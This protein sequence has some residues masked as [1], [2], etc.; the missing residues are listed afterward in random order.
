MIIVWGR[1][2]I[3]SVQEPVL[4][5]GIANNELFILVWT[6]KTIMLAENKFM[7]NVQILMKD[8]QLFLSFLRE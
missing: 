3:Y 2:F 6:I 1:S 5:L 8:C 7:G 4:E